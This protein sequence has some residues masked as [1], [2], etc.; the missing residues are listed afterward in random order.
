MEGMEGMEGR[1]LLPVS[2]LHWVNH[3]SNPPT[4]PPRKSATLSMYSQLR[5]GQFTNTMAGPARLN[6]MNHV[7]HHRP[8]GR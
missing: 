8:H 3:P 2:K 7:Q 5:N 1:V 6:L 4:H